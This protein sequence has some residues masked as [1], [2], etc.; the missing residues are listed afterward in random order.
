MTNSHVDLIRL[1]PTQLYAL[2]LFAISAVILLA[3]RLRGVS[4][5]PAWLSDD[6]GL[7]PGGA[8][9]REVKSM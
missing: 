7:G 2:A 1:S 5:G 9:N 6:S 3:W 4:T 8:G